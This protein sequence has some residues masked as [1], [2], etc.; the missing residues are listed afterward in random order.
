MNLAPIPL[1]PAAPCCDDP[2]CHNGMLHWYEAPEPEV[3][4]PGGEYSEP[5]PYCEQLRE[6][7]AAL[8]ASDHRYGNPC[9]GPDYPT[10]Y[11]APEGY[12]PDAS[13]LF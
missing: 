13:V 12:T 9:H 11:G 8:D 6:D 3:G 1:P 4:Y 2:D 10:T 5:C 7:Q